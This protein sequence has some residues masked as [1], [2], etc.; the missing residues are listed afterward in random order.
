MMTCE[1]SLAG[2]QCCA[3]VGG[4]LRRSAR[5][6]V[7]APVDSA[8]VGRQQELV[9]SD[10]AELDELGRSVA[11]TTDRALV[12]AYGE[13]NARGR[14]VRVRR[15]TATAGPRSRSSWRATASSSTSSDTRSRS[16]ATASWSG[17]TERAPIAGAAYVFV[18]SGASWIEEQKLVAS[19]GVE[20]DNFGWSVSLAA[21]RALVGATGVTPLA[22]RPTSS[23]GAA[24]HGPRSR[25]SS[26]LTVPSLTI[27]VG[28]SR[29]PP[30]NG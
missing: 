10:A 5:P 30:I 15:G 13:S 25:S 20:G 23:S 19:D 7:R 11:L 2:R 3:V 6:V 21:D 18:R 12:G 1:S 24:T 29:S 26:R 28:P 8:G 27:S 16:P 22:A 4:E 9:A 17:R 14:G